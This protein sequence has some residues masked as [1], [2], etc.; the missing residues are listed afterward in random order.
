MGRNEDGLIVGGLDGGDLSEPIEDTAEFF[1]A[2]PGVQ[3]CYVGQFNVM[4]HEQHVFGEDGSP[5]LLEDSL[6]LT[7]LKVDALDQTLAGAFGEYAHLEA[8]LTLISR[9]RHRAPQPHVLGTHW[10]STPTGAST[11][12]ITPAN[13]TGALTVGH[14][15]TALIISILESQDSAVRTEGGG[16]CRI[17]REHRGGNISD[18][19]PLVYLEN[20]RGA[21]FP[22]LTDPAGTGIT[23]PDQIT[24]RDHRFVVDGFGGVKG[25]GV[26]SA[27]L[28]GEIGADFLNVSRV[29]PDSRLPVAGQTHLEIPSVGPTDGV[30][31]VGERGLA[32]AIPSDQSLDEAE[33]D[34]PIDD[35]IRVFPSEFS[36]DAVLPCG[37]AID[38]AF[39]EDTI[40]T[41]PWTDDVELT[42]TDGDGNVVKVS[43]EILCP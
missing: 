16:I 31:C 2:E 30:V 12:G 41:S 38:M 4:N 23:I 37:A 3:P 8:P 14:V 7:Q 39:S 18:T 28:S 5:Y 24:D 22:F 35:K 15:P 13:Q 9:N 34:Q 27:L 40:V 21:T 11:R 33:I 29:N 32:L 17:I 25:A 36:V 26:S 1:P 19:R 6:R 43:N 20:D 10:T 42:V